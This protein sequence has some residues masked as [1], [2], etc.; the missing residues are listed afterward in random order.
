MRFNRLASHRRLPSFPVRRVKVPVRGCWFEAAL[1][2]KYAL[3]GETICKRRKSESC[4][5]QG[6]WGWKERPCSLDLS[7]S[8]PRPKLG[9][10]TDRSKSVGERPSPRSHQPRRA[11]RRQVPGRV[12][13]RLRHRQ[14]ERPGTAQGP[15]HGVRSLQV[16]HAS[17]GV[18][19]RPAR[20]HYLH[21]AGHRAR[22]LRRSRRFATPLCR[23]SCHV[24]PQSERKEEVTPTPT[25]QPSGAPSK[26]CLGG[27]PT[28][29]P[30]PPKCAPESN[31]PWP[32]SADWCPV[33]WC[34]SLRRLPSSPQS[35][36]CQLW[37]CGT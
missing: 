28:N 5:F 31:T 9:V 3:L 20:R 37:I 30:A 14:R 33:P 17:R 11:R 34:A 18:P 13:P 1:W 26:L 21:R 12:P 23:T 19:K 8:A 22:S 35:F 16:R 24:H 15:P 25:L 29:P 27:K 10:L 36:T 4:R 32:N 2:F 7:S 6:W